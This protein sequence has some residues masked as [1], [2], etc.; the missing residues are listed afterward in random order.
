MKNIPIAIISIIGLFVFISC[1]TKNHNEFRL[2]IYTPADLD[3]DWVD[4]SL[5]NSTEAH[6]VNDFD[7]INQNGLVVNEQTIEGKIYIA[8]FFFTTCPGICPTLIKHTKKIQD[9]FL[10]DHD[11]LILSH[12]VY[13]EHDSVSVLYAF[14]KQRN[15]NS[16]KWHL[17]TGSKQDL[18]TISRKGYF[19]I[20]YQPDLSN[21]GFI[22]TENVVLVDKQRRLRGIYNGTNVHEMNRLIEDIYLLKKE[23]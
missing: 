2:P 1:D 7:F 19:A 23:Y 3:P 10:N 4:S 22:H 18:Y 9:E 20:S 13:P 8:E 21:D 16:E 17:L 11:V 5:K 15:I 14:G 6:V 12:T